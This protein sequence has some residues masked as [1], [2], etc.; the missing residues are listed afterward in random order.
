ME[1]FCGT[2][3]SAIRSRRFPWA[4]IDRR[5]RDMVQ[6]AQCE[7]CYN[8]PELSLRSQRSSR[9]TGQIELELGPRSKLEESLSK[10]TEN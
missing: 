2:L 6:L 8:M 1:R 5:L 10:E 7:L 9:E 4:S 3:Q